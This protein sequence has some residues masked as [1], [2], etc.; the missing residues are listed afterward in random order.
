[1]NITD[2]ENDIFTVSPGTQPDNYIYPVLR[3]TWNARLS[4][5]CSTIARLS[6]AAC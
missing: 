5:L 1:M 2:D 6:I 4:S 3:S